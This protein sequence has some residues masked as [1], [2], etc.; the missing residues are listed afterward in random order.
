[1]GRPHR[2]RPP[3]HPGLRDPHSLPHRQIKRQMGISCSIKVFPS[4]ILNQKDTH[5]SVFEFMSL[6]LFQSTPYPVVHFPTRKPLG[7]R[8]AAREE[9][10]KKARVFSFRGI[11]AFGIPRFPTAMF[12]D[13]A[14]VPKPKLAEYFEDDYFEQSVWA[15]THNFT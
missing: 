1:M 15:A 13:F 8:Q 14:W 5:K 11:S 10:S 6:Q 2:D 12:E 3:F 7:S 9:L 4:K